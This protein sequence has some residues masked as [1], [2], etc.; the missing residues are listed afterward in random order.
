MS[1]RSFGTNYLN[2]VAAPLSD[3]SQDI[4]P[5]FDFIEPSHPQWDI[6]N[7]FDHP[8]DF[9]NSL[10][11]DFG[12]Y[13]T[14]SLPHQP[15]PATAPQ[16]T[17]SFQPSAY[18]PPQAGTWDIY[19]RSLEISGSS[20]FTHLASQPVAATP[21]TAVSQPSSE[22][23]ATPPSATSR[24]PPGSGDENKTHFW[25]DPFIEDG[26]SKVRPGQW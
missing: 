11:Y 14:T 8:T 12:T 13:G 26:R 10:S 18:M 16:E 7:L 21:T 2:V 22:S 6:P 3:P 15:E 20:T 24:Y 19:A 4:Q 23:H 25:S 17:T 1:H 9:I 5:W